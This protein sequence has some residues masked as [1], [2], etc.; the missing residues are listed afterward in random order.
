MLN[1]IFMWLRRRSVKNATDVSAWK[2]H[3]QPSFVSWS[4]ANKYTHIFYTNNIKFSSH[5]IIYS[6]AGIWDLELDF[7]FSRWVGEGDKKQE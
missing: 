5:E 2:A 1:F 3:V 7:F 6:F 4:C